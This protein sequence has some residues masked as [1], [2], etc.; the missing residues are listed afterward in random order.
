[1]WNLGVCIKRLPQLQNFQGKEY[2]GTSFRS[3]MDILSGDISQ[4]IEAVSN[5][6]QR[7]FTVALIGETGTGK[8]SLL[9]SLL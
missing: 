8:T 6:I 2:Q 4:V 9:N 1:M 5:E 3:I 7:P